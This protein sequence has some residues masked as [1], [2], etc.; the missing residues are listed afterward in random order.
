MTTK[1]ST[2]TRLNTR[3]LARHAR[4]AIRERLLYPAPW[5]L[6]AVEREGAAVILRVNSG[7]N[8]L[9]V[10]SYLRQRGY[11]AEYAGTNPDGYGGA[12]RVTLR[13]AAQAGD[14]R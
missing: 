5:A 7:G 8:V 3:H 14:R 12:V 4:K 13:K 11:C 1:R 9:A 10:E 6:L 2:P